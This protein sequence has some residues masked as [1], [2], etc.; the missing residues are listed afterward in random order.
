MDQEWD[1]ARCKWTPSIS[2]GRS[3]TQ[4]GIHG[5]TQLL[6]VHSYTMTILLLIVIITRLL[7]P[8]ICSCIAQRKW[9]RVYQLT[10]AIFYFISVFLRQIRSI[11]YFLRIR[12]PVRS[13]FY[14]LARRSWQWMRPL[15]YLSSLS[16]HIH[17]TIQESAY[18]H[19][20]RL[21]CIRYWI[22]SY[23]LLCL[24]EFRNFPLAFSTSL[25]LSNTDVAWLCTTFI[26]QFIHFFCSYHGHWH[27]NVTRSQIFSACIYNSNSNWTWYMHDRS[28]GYLLIPSWSRFRIVY[29]NICFYLRIWDLWLRSR[30]LCNH[31][32]LHSPREAWWIWTQSLHLQRIAQG[33]AVSSLRKTS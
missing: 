14:I 18:Y 11:G 21:I 19:H 23:T 31:P 7:R 1:L 27:H 3:C 16:F 17:N 28:V 25:Y 33:I 4:A 6:Y 13:W 12:W 24:N 5:S 20:Q 32:L 8:I 9:H 15:S 30:F 2:T 29:R 26:I 10:V 22:L